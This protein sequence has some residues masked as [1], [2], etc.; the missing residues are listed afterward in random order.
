VVLIAEQPKENE[1]L[2]DFS[3]RFMTN[4]Q[5][6]PDADAH[7]P[8]K[9]CLAFKADQPGMYHADGDGHGR[10][11][12]FER[13]QPAYPGLIFEA[14]SGPPVSNGSSGPQYFRPNQIEKRM[15]GK[16]YYLVMLDTAASI[17]APAVKDYEFFLENLTAE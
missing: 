7:C 8:V 15:P 2:A 3:R 16:L 10:I 12:F 14:P 5:F 17:E 6:T 11:L 4:G 13:D 1:T 9:A